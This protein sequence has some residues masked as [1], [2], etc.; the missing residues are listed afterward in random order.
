MAITQLD[1]AGV[2]ERRIAQIAGHQKGKSESMKTY[3]KGA[4]MQELATYIEMIKYEGL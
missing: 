1:R 4:D 3:S 2:P